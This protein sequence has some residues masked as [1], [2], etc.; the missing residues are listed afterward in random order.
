MS[1]YKENLEVKFNILNLTKP[2]SLYTQGLLPLVLSMQAKSFKQTDWHRAGQFVS[3]TQ[4]NIQRKYHQ[5]NG[6]NYYF[7][8]SFTYTFEFSNDKVYFSHCYP[9]TYTNLLDYLEELSENPGYSEY[10]KITSLC[11]T[12]AGNVCPLLTITEGIKSYD[13]L[14]S[15]DDTEKFVDFDTHKHKKAIVLTA[16]VHPG[17]T[18]SSY[19]IKGTIDFLLS[20]SHQ[21]RALRKKFLFKIVPMLNPD[22]VIYGNYRCSLLGVDLN[23]R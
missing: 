19:M 11:K 12:L 15:L 8:L 4:N 9:Y 6:C 1:N 18:N 23:R 3:Y 13:C 20:N 22:G 10:L 7:T 16:R 14:N 5:A 17:E 21:A 2:E